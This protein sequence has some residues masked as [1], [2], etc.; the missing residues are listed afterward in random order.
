MNASATSPADELRTVVAK[1]E[2]LIASLENSG[3][4]S[5]I[6][7]RTRASQV[8][9]TA[10]DRLQSIQDTTRET[11]TGAARATDEYVRENPW[12]TLAYGVVFGMFVG[13]LLARRG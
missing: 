5:V 3:E 12:Q 10:K 11:V 1:A 6:K 2:R 9:H 7:L 4:D 8:L 13:A